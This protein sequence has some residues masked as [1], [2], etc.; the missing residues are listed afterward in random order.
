MFFLNAM[1]TFK[2][3]IQKFGDKGEK[4]GWIYISISAAQADKLNPKVK[5]SYRVKGKIDELAV[6][7]VALLP[8][9]KG[10]F[11]IPINATMRKV[12]RKPVGGIVTVSLTV[13]K[14]ALKLSEDFISCLE[15][16]PVAFD[17]FSKLAPGHQ[18]Y[19]S[20]WIDSAK[21]EQTKVKRITQSIQG[22]AMG[23]D[24]GGTIRYFKSKD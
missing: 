8:M 12:I 11:I 13:D 10:S 23:L 21:T 17:N 1:V 22:L 5:T 19:F 24:Y 15:M 3:V 7:Q 14:T 6:K 4:T 9:G 20:K 2:C 16:E 18:R